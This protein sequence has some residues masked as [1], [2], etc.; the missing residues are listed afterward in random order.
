M[1]EATEASIFDGLNNHLKTQHAL[2]DALEKIADGLPSNV[3]RQECL[4]LAKSIFP[5]VKRA[6]EFEE[7]NLF[8]IFSQSKYQ[9]DPEAVLARLH[10]E[11]WEDESYALEL[12][13][14]LTEF[15]ANSPTS[16]P[17]ALGYMLRG[18]FGSLR[19]HIA[20]EE[21]FFNPK[22]TM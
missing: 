7:K 1:D 5:I 13:D 9:A 20:S 10:S 21:E 22:L 19:R 2:C 12:Q 18:F 16:N 14:A 6:H 15:A 17:E 8:P 3:D 11:H 4:H